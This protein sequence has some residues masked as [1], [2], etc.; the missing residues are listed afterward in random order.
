MPKA[1]KVM[2]PYKA[3]GA[4]RS[5]DGAFIDLSFTS[6]TKASYTKVWR[7]HVDA[8]EVRIARVLVT[9]VAK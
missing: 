7:R 1:A 5:R 3:W 6:S 9:E 2:K 8:G 4:V